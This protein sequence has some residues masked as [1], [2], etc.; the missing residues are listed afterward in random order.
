[1]L[2]TRF[3]RLIGCNVPIQQAGMG[4]VATAELASA[5]AL[6]GA[7]GMIGGVRLGAKVLGEEL[8]SLPR[9]TRSRI[10]VNFLVPFLDRESL[11]VA[12]SRVRVV[13]F[14]TASPMPTWSSAPLEPAPWRPGRSARWRKRVLPQEPVAISWSHKGSKL[15]ATCAAGSA[16]C[17]FSTACSMQ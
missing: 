15:A 3:T 1:M 17:P 8:D 4:G 10:G 11:E 5:V 16:C 14:S 7:L 12:A 13:E 6:A 2:T 9:Q